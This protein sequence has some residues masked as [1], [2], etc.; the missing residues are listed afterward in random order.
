M[1][2]HDQEKTALAW[3]RKQAQEIDPDIDE[4]ANILDCARVISAALKIK[5]VDTAEGQLRWV[6][7]KEGDSG[8]NVQNRKMQQ[9]SEGQWLDIPIIIEID[10]KGQTVME[11]I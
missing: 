6:L 4:Y 2:K 9:Y 11:Q 3:M 1:K 8:S 5:V 7:D 10:V